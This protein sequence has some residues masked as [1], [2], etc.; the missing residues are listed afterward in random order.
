MSPPLGAPTRHRLLARSRRQQAQTEPSARQLINCAGYLR[1]FLP[2]GAVQERA[3]T[4][5]GPYTNDALDRANKRPD[6]DRSR[7]I[8]L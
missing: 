5:K 3:A 2:T 6:V 1:D 7:D 8:A 4:E